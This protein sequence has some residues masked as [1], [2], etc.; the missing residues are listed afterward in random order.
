MDDKAYLIKQIKKLRKIDYYYN[1]LILIIIMFFIL[2]CPV[3]IYNIIIKNEFLSAIL[4][5]FAEVF[6]ITLSVNYYKKVRDLSANKRS[7]ILDCIEN[8]EKVTE[9]I[10]L[11]NR[12]LFEIKGKQDDSIVLKESEYRSQII[13]SIKLV[14]INANIVVNQS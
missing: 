4:L 2:I 14:F 13:E 6:F 9:I 12:I 5:I 3:V 8:P 10:I 7:R 1:L 11:P